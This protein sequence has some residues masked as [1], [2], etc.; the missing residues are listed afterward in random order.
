LINVKKE[1]QGLRFWALGLCCL[2]GI[3]LVW[4]P[5]VIDDCYDREYTCGYCKETWV[6]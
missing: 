4:I 2:G 1:G 6:V 5:Y 3:L